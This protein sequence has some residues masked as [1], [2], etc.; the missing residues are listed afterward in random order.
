MLSRED[1][2]KNISGKGMTDLGLWL[3]RK[4][5]EMYEMS[6]GSLV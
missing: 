4:K 5:S 6:G 2:V 1:L 3:W